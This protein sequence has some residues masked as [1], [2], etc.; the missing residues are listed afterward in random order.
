MIV[1]D[2]EF[3]QPLFG[4]LEKCKGIWQMDCHHPEGDVFN[5]SLQVLKWAFRETI[6]TDLIL[7]AMMHD[8]G[9]VKD[10][11]GHDKIAVKML[12]SYLSAK[13]LWLIEHHMRIWYYILGDMKK[14]SKVKELAEHPWLPELVQL[15][16]WDKMGR[17]PNVKPVYDK[18]KI[19]ERLNLCVEKR[20]EGNNEN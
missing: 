1:F 16:R 18:D 7:A 3:M 4:A 19:M 11:L 8:V 5:H 15:A 10:S 9:K 6:D 2:N 20:F 12:D 13:S 17:N 14:L